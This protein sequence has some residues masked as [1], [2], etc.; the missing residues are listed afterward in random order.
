MQIIAG[1]YA[2]RKLSSPGGTNVRPPLTRLRRAVFDTLMPFLPRG[3]YLDLFGG[4]GSFAFEALSR[5]ASNATV[6]EL[7][8]RTAKEIEANFR[9]LKA[10][11]PLRLCRGNALKWLPKLA[12]E[13]QSFAVIGVAPPY[14]VDLEEKTMAILGPLAESLVQ[15]DGIVFLQHPS[16][17]VVPH[18]V[19][20]LEYWKTRKYGNT[21]VTYYLRPQPPEP[22][23]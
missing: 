13:G 8:P 11:E 12:A 2:G 7:N 15:E 9:V 20:G 14:W 16:K 21:T 4:T 3:A 18:D 19:P 17:T 22:T 6:V 5:G 10:D 1:K 23:E